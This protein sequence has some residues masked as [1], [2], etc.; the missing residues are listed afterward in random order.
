MSINLEKIKDGNIILV[1]LVLILIISFGFY[2]YLSSYLF[3]QK[4]EESAKLKTEFTELSQLIMS[5]NKGD[6]SLA[7]NQI[8]DFQVL[9]ENAPRTSK[10]FER[11]ELWAHPGIIYSSFKLESDSRKISMLGKTKNNRNLMEQIV[12]LG[13]EGSIESYELLNINMTEGGE[14]TFELNLIIKSILLK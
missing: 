1:L 13:K 11:F 2:F 6:L 7:Q 5:E 4:E 10:F 8:N 14:V 3:P 12:F 9:L